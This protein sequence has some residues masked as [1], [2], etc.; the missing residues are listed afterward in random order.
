MT[1]AEASKL[2][3]TD[4]QAWVSWKFSQPGQ[5]ATQSEAQAAAYAKM[6][7][8]TRDNFQYGVSPNHNGG[9][10]VAMYSSD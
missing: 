5:Y 10:D 4:Y 2:Y 9:W 8:R 6:N 7:A 3:Q 1:Q